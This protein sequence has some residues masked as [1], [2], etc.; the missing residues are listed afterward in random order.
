MLELQENDFRINYYSLLNVKIDADPKSIKIAYRKKAMEFHPD[1]NKSIDA[2]DMFKLVNRAYEI[3]RDPKL[4][5]RYDL[6]RMDSGDDIQ[7]DMNEDKTWSGLEEYLDLENCYAGI[8]DYLFKHSD[9]DKILA[10]NSKI[11]E[12][13]SDIYIKETRAIQHNRYNKVK[14]LYKSFENI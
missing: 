12:N 10:I 5:K 7:P 3:L 13:G 1:R 11:L 6:E 14:S 2:E 9:A 8:Y 4:K